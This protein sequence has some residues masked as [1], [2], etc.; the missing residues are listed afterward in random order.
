MVKH[1]IAWIAMAMILATFA[2]AQVNNGELPVLDHPHDLLFPDD[3]ECLDLFKMICSEA[4]RDTSEP[5]LEFESHTREIKGITKELFQDYMK[6][7]DSTDQQLE[8]HH[9]HFK[10]TIHFTKRIQVIWPFRYEIYN[11]D[12]GEIVYID[13]DH[14]HSEKASEATSNAGRIRKTTFPSGTHVIEV[15]VKKDAAGFTMKRLKSISVSMPIMGPSQ[16]VH[17][18]ND[19]QVMREYINHLVTGKKFDLKSPVPTVKKIEREF[20]SEVW[21][22]PRVVPLAGPSQLHHKRF[23]CTIYFKDGNGRE[24]NDEVELEFNHFHILTPF[25]PDGDMDVHALPIPLP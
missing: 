13:R 10:V 14:I 6:P 22:E 15:P 11:D 5:G 18:P 24:W 21:D 25:P 8:V 1:I 4:N 9:L 17:F 7:S 2:H 3:E 19:D 12:A 20:L 16:C 23:L